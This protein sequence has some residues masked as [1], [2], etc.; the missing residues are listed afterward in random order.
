MFITFLK[1]LHYAFIGLGLVD[2]C[3]VYGVLNRNSFE[4]TSFII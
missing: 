3:S 1:D 4:W 2:N